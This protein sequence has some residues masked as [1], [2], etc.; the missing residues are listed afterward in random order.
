MLLEEGVRLRGDGRLGG[1]RFGDGKLSD[2][3]RAFVFSVIYDFCGYHGN[4]TVEVRRRI[5][6]I[7]HVYVAHLLN[8]YKLCGACCRSYMCI[9]MGVMCMYV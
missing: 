3:A 6:S 2:S 1:G 5:S 9:C 4:N 7:V 8:S